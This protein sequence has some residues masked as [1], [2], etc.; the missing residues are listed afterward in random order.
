VT[1]DLDTYCRRIGYDG[2][3]APTLATLCA[4]HELHP[5]SIAFE[6][7]DPL[8]GRPVRL[9][10]ASLHG[11]ML[12]GGRGGYCFEHNLLFGHVLRAMGFKVRELIGRPRW[13]MPD[14]VITP[15]IHML[16]LIDLEQT[17]YV[18]DVGFGGNTLTGPLL[19][20]SREEQSTPHEPARVVE[21]AGQWSI[22]VKIRGGW[23][24]TYI[25][26]LSEQLL[27]DLETSNWWTSSNP[28][29]P[30]VNELRLARTEVGGRYTLRN[31]ELARHRLNS[32]TE[33]SMLRTVPELRDALSDIFLLRLAEIGELDKVLVRY[34]AGEA[35]SA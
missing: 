21:A 17:Q 16:L 9:D 8:L 7:L 35:R 29:S 12:Q 3:R 22:Q 33:R 31:N 1:I 26:D 30:F 13:R 4:L 20:H 14:S 24:T 23:A 2:E 11:K 15:R 27:I 6:N 5:R 34:A 28:D 32:E 19:L 25:F 18:A 10:P